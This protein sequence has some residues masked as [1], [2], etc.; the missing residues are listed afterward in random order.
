MSSASLRVAFSRSR[1]ASC[2]SSWLVLKARMVE[3]IPLAAWVVAAT[4]SSVAP[5]STASGSTSLLLGCAD[6]G[7]QRPDAEARHER[8]DDASD[9]A[10]VPRLAGDDR[11]QPE[12]DARD[13]P[14]AHRR[15]FPDLLC[16]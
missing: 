5:V 10:G 7:H 15:L 11:E 4:R 3:M 12:D 6:R 8:S 13:E 16:D 2:S 14:E 9:G 1:H